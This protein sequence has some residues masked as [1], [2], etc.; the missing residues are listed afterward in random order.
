MGEEL[1]GSENF[2]IN[3]DQL[4]LVFTFNYKPKRILKSGLAT[5]VFWE[6]GSKTVVKR[7][8]DE[9]D[10]EYMAFTAALAKR[11]FGSNNAIKKIIKTKTEVQKPKND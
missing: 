6:D 2:T 11:V 9:P 7:S 4:H 10:N 5:I 8:P 3:L 1:M